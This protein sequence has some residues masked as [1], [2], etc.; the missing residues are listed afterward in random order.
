MCCLWVR[1]RGRCLNCYLVD[2]LESDTHQLE[3]LSKASRLCT[4]H[5]RCIDWHH[6]PLLKHL[7]ACRHHAWHENR[8]AAPAVALRTAL[9]RVDHRRLEINVSVTV[10]LISP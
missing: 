5:E 6:S 8:I 2:R 3:R 1:C 9:R 10:V 4:W 7:I